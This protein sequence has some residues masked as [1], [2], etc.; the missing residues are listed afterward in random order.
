MSRTYAEWFDI[1]Y[2]DV[3]VLSPFIGGGFGSKAFAMAHSA[4]AAIAADR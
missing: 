2:E 4:I 3:R 1:A